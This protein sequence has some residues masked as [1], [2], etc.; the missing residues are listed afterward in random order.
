[1]T[2]VQTQLTS[3]GLENSIALADDLLSSLGDVPEGLVRN[4]RQ[5]L[6]ENRVVSVL[7]ST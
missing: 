5:D 7:N 6:S 4:T 3:C 2:N 1:M